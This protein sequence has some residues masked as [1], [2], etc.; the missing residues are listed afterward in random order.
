M[1]E[2]MIKEIRQIHNGNTGKWACRGILPARPGLSRLEVIVLLIVLGVLLAL[3]FPAIQFS[4]EYM[5]RSACSNNIRQLCK[6]MAE[7]HDAN[8]SLPLIGCYTA[9]EKDIPMGQS[10]RYDYPRVNSVVALLPFLGFAEESQQILGMAKYSEDGSKNTVAGVTSGVPAMGKQLPVLHCPSEITPNMMGEGSVM[11]QVLP[12][13][14]RNYLYCMG[15]YPEAGAFPYCQTTRDKVNEETVQMYRQ[16]NNNT[17]GAIIGLDSY[18]D[19]S[20]IADGMSKTIL[21]G[22]RVLG[23]NGTREILTTARIGSVS[24]FDTSP[25]RTS[26]QMDCVDPAHRGK[27]PDVWSD[28]IGVLGLVGGLRAYCAIVA[29]SGFSTIL[30][31]GEVSCVAHANG[32]SMLSASSYHSGGVNV[33]MY[34]GAVHFVNNR[35]NASTDD[36]E[37]QFIKEAGP[38]NFGVWGSM[39]A[40]DEST[41]PQ[42]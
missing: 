8:K 33:G 32:R 3:I 12:L 20:Y 16:F 17:R 23:K 14:S 34:D 5:R 1:I 36:V 26:P 41:V 31:P 15:D 38:S 39:G 11:G 37:Y 28:G 42:L 7:Y 21:W 24:S 9:G 22:E 10:V 2:K 6:A 19:F 29:F 40:V 30:P 18:R 35:I 27:T 25:N 13:A 4:R